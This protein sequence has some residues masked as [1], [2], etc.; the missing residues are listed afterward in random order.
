VIELA[1]PGWRELRLEHLVLDVNGTLALDGF[2]LPGVA[3]RLAALRGA[4]TIHLL[5]ADTHGRLDEAA[6]ELGVTG[7]R[8][9]RDE[10]EPSQKAAH[11]RRLGPASVV[12][13]GN[14]HNDVEML[15]EAALGIAVLGPE[16]TAV[17]AVIS[18]HVLAASIL[19]ALDLLLF[20]K[21][22][23]ATLRR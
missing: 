7:T 22:L 19:D 2:L 10:P 17:E 8:L 23:I 12:A 11:L 21:R 5:S 4:L 16:G 14:G 1:V 13:I 3:E 6:R 18:A 9:R 15:R 20:P